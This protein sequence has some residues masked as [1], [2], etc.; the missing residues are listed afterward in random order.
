MAGAARLDRREL[1]RRL[2]GQA[3]AWIVDDLADAFEA[4]AGA[5]MR[6][7]SKRERGNDDG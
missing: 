1:I 2:D 5:A 3:E 4:A 7:K 6:P